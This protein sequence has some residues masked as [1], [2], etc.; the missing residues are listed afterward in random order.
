V[1]QQPFIARFPR[2]PHAGRPVSEVAPFLP[3]PETPDCL[4]NLKNLKRRI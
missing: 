1:N 3:T 2:R 4:Q